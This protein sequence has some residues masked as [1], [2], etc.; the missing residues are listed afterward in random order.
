MTWHRT[1]TRS[2]RTADG[3][4]PQVTVM[5]CAVDRHTHRVADSELRFGL[6]QGQG[7]YKAVCGRQITAASL[8]TPPGLACP[9]CRDR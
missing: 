2:N 1:A 9:H 6:V 8:S 5:T 3:A 7:T 4:S